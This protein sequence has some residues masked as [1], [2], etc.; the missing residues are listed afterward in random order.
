MT[1]DIQ[2]LVAEIAKDRTQQYMEFTLYSPSGAR[3]GEFTPLT[4]LS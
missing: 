1:G 4:V 3:Y 2:S